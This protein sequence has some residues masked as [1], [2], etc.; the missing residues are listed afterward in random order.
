MAE[1]EGTAILR[2][3]ADLRKESR[4]DAESLGLLPR[5]T[6]VKLN[7]DS[8]GSFTPVVVE[9]EEGEL[10][11]FI[12]TSALR[13]SVPKPKP[14]EEVTDEEKKPSKRG[15]RQTKRRAPY[16]PRDEQALLRREPSFSYG[17]LA[18]AHY[19]MLAL[20][21][22]PDDTY[23]GMGTTL[24]AHLSLFLDPSFRLRGEVAY[25]THG[26]AAADETVAGFGFMDFAVLGEFLFR[27]AF[28]L[29]GGLQYSFGAGIRELS[30]TIPIRSASDLNSFWLQLGAGYRFSLG[31]MTYLSLRGRYQGSLSVSPVQFYSFGVAAY[32]EIQG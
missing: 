12:A 10:T 4:A 28:L 22:V 7:G 13:L 14:V 17:I 24:G 29:F 27:P 19:S 25:T 1:E 8:A 5:G 21:D 6:I 3:E 31:E 11:G 2:R 32:L 16:V 15:T 30:N 23:G 20:E 26:G 9:V 18:G